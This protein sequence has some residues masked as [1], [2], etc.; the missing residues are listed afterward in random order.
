MKVSNRNNWYVIDGYVYSPGTNIDIILDATDKFSDV[1][2]SRMA[3]SNPD[4]PELLAKSETVKDVKGTL[5]IS[6][7]KTKITIRK[8][9]SYST[10]VP[11]MVEESFNACKTSSEKGVDL[12]EVYTVA[13]AKTPGFIHYTLSARGICFVMPMDNGVCYLVK[14]SNNYLEI[15]PLEGEY[16]FAHIHLGKVASLFSKSGTIKEYTIHQHQS[17]ATKSTVYLVSKENSGNRIIFN[18]FVPKLDS[19]DTIKNIV[20]NAIN[21][22]NRVCRIGSKVYMDIVSSVTNKTLQMQ[23]NKD[24]TILV[25]F[26]DLARPVE[27]SASADE[28]EVSDAFTLNGPELFQ[29][30]ISKA[31]LTP[32]V[33]VCRGPKTLVFKIPIKGN[34]NRLL[35]ICPIR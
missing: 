16:E 7:K 25:S 5:I 15:V 13:T 8:Y 18:E 14:G 31:E 20:I 33:H 10:M 23:V 29:Y 9:V 32:D 1:K 17:S 22:D 21:N 4:F 2:R 30:K 28:L 26:S 12:E 6:Y 24:S 34:E 27:F 3:I 19:L 11:A 35:G